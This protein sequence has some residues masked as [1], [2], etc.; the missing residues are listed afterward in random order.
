MLLVGDLIGT[1]G[2][3]LDSSFDVLDE[4]NSTI[5]YLMLSTFYFSIYTA[6]SMTCHHHSFSLSALVLRVSEVVVFVENFD[7]GL[8]KIENPRPDL[9]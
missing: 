7:S 4:I 9:P 8:R 6:L 5:H 1:V 2:G 3:L